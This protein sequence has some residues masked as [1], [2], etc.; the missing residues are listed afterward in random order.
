MIEPIHEEGSIRDSGQW[1][2]EGKVLELRL[3]GTLLR[4]IALDAQKQNVTR[5]CCKRHCYDFRVERSAI[6][7]PELVLRPSF[8][9]H[10]PSGRRSTRLR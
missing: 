1:V 2:M 3:M 9:S 8:T 10:T 6:K 7:A 5:G 4:N